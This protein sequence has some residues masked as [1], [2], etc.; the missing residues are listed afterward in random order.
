M[1]PSESE[2]LDSDLNGRDGQAGSD[3]A[4][5]RQWLTVQTYDGD[6]GLFRLR[7]SD[8][9]RRA[10][11]VGTSPDDLLW[12]ASQAGDCDFS[13]SAEALAGRVAIETGKVWMSLPWSLSREQP[14]VPSAPGLC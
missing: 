3:S 13:G 9:E 11:W 5:E 7:D 1:E 14:Q 4:N 2:V 10:A 12:R 8:G 6:I